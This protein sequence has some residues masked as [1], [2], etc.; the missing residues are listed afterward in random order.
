MCGFLQGEFLRFSR[1]YILSRGMAIGHLNSSKQAGLSL[2]NTSRLAIRRCILGI[3]LI[4][5]KNGA[6]RP[7]GNIDIGKSGAGMGPDL[8]RWDD[9]LM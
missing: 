2:L 1:P 4:V 9:P 8:R 3:V 7:V 6:N 5:R